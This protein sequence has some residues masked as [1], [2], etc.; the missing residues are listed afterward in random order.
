MISTP[1]NRTGRAPPAGPNGQTATRWVL[2]LNRHVFVLRYLS[3]KGILIMWIR[4]NAPITIFMCQLLLCVQ[5]SIAEP[6]ALRCVSVLQEWKMNDLALYSSCPSGEKG[7]GKPWGTVT[8]TFDLDAPSTQIPAEI[9]RQTCF[10]S[11]EL[12]PGSVTPFPNHLQ[13]KY[14]IGFGIV[15]TETI[16]RR[17]LTSDQ[18]DKCSL[19][20]PL[21]SENQI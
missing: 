15:T 17:T 21:S 18:G 3:I 16:N 14:S 7:L 5:A 12:Y 8:Y 19:A 4:K 6:R 10:G 11:D 13:F 20:A 9:R 1:L 2:G